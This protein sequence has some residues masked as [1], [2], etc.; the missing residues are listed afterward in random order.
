[1]LIENIKDY[2]IALLDPEGTV[3]SWN[4]AAQALKG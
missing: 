1:L 3:I 4:P 2:A